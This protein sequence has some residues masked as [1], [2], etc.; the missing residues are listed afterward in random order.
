MNLTL[1]PAIAGFFQAHN[2]GQTA[3]LLDLFTPEAMVRDEAHEY[4]G[5]AIKDW[6]DGAIRKY[7]PQATVT[8]LTETGAQNV[9]TA[10]VSGNFP[11]SPV[12]LRYRFTL[13]DGKIAALA[14]GD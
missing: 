5:A 7:Q 1:P 4:R 2:S 13:K 12:E 10:Q 3:Q 9:A 8:A 14:I 6:L 11:G